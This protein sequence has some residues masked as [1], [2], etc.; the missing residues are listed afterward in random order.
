M[1]D[2][3]TE[4]RWW[5]YS[6]GLAALGGL[7]RGLGCDRQCF[8]YWGLFQRVAAALLIGILVTLILHQSDLP[9]TMKTAVAGAAGYSANDILEAM[10]PWIKRR[11]GLK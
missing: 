9:E 11:L 2:Y 10:K 4:I 3:L 1:W 5:L 8:T 6:V 7:V